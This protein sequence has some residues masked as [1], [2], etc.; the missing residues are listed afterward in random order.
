M[1]RASQYKANAEREQMR[2]SA[3]D[4]DSYLRSLKM[5]L[6]Y[7]PFDEGNLPRIAQ[8]IG[9]TNQFNL[10]TR[11][12]S[13]E[14]LRGIMATPN[15]VTLQLALTD[16]FGDNGTISLVIGYAEDNALRID[17]WLMSCR[18]L[19]RGVETMVLK[20]ILAEALRRGVTEVFGTYLPTD[21]NALVVDH[22]R[23]LGFEQL[24]ADPDGRTEWRIRTETEIAAPPMAVERLGGAVEV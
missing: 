23:K 24:S 14:E 17:T 13:A 22:Y 1:E 8:L 15:A 3:T 11:R 19:G 7:R 16:A 20:E 12:Y 21:R 4:L 2:A 9:K 10:T 6:R 5:E 18:V